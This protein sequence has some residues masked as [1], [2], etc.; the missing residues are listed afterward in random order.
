MVERPSKVGVVT[1]T[2][3]S[4]DVIEDFMESMLSQSY[5]IFILYIVDNAST[6]DTL[7]RLKNYDDSRIVILPNNT[8]VGVA[9]G[10][11]QGIEKAVSNECG[12]ILLI[13][14]DVEFEQSMLE[15]LMDSMSKCNCDV[16]VPKMIYHD[17]KSLIWFAGGYF[18]KWKGY[19][20]YHIG[21]N[22]HDNG[23]YDYQKQIQYAPTCCM[24]IKKCV[25]DIVGIMDEKYFVYFDDTDFCY[26][27]Y[28]HNISMYY[29]P[30]IDF[31][32]K[33]S[34]L[35]GGLE[36]HFT[37]RHMIRNKVY[38]LLK[39]N[40]VLKYIYCVLF[41]IKTITCFVFSKR[42]KKNYDVFKLINLSFVEGFY[43]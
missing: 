1:V 42:F 18:S 7:G 39:Q 19:S 3:N 25:F 28:K 43:L 41:Y 5:E 23:Q 9:A 6:D 21:M 38:Y 35:T 12:H 20:N 24:L 2:Y 17:N 37:I 4:G 36:S 14:N 33:V 10:N 40:N 31:Y 27:L 15:K 26:R 22:E 8:N 34:S 32:H 29:Y 30:H 13:N 16:I 11:N